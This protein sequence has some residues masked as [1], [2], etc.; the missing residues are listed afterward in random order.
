MPLNIQDLFILSLFSKIDQKKF[1]LILTK[2]NHHKISIDSFLLYIH[3]LFI[4]Y[5]IKIHI[6][7]QNQIKKMILNRFKSKRKLGKGAYG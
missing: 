2:I 4:K 5:N 7:K 3:K 1:Y 6:P